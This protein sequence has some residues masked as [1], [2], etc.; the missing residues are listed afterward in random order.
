MNDL[1]LSYYHHLSPYLGEVDEK[2]KTTKKARSW[3]FLIYEE[4]GKEADIFFYKL[5]HSSTQWFVS[6]LHEDSTTNENGVTLF[7]KAHY[8][9]LIIFPYPVHR[10][11]VARIV[12]MSHLP[13]FFY[14]CSDVFATIRYFVHRGYDKRQYDEKEIQTNSIIMRN[15]AFLPD[16]SNDCSNQYRLL[17]RALDTMEFAT[18]VDFTLWV[19][20]CGLTKVYKKYEKSIFC[21]YFRSDGYSKTYYRKHK[22]ELEDD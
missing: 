10:N 21:V 1:V 19:E 4:W 15:K 8:H 12:G 9:C 22:K 14:S 18:I 6:P 7:L 5:Y 20:D 2:G 17:L 11:Y 13:H 3:V 16:S